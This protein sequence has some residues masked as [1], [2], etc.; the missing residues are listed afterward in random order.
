MVV[1][2]SPPRGCRRRP[3]GPGVDPMAPLQSARE[4]LGV[5]ARTRE[6]LAGPPSWLETAARVCID[7]AT[8]EPAAFVSFWRRPTQC[9][10]LPERFNGGREVVAGHGQPP[11]ARARPKEWSIFY[12]RD[13]LR[14]RFLFRCVP[15]W[16]AAGQLVAMAAKAPRCFL[17][18]GWGGWRCAKGPPCSDRFGSFY[19]ISPSFGCFTRC[20]TTS[21]LPRRLCVLGWWLH[22]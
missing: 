13:L 1:C 14:L 9:Q 3:P 16:T 4:P 21:P 8:R 18:W 22:L 2:L 6:G 7:F 10:L 17:T 5:D 11:L 19:F 20:R 15:P 12:L